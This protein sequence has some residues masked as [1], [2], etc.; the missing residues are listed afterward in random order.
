MSLQPLLLAL[1]CQAPDSPPAGQPDDTGVD[2]GGV[3]GPVSMAPGDVVDMAVASDGSVWAELA[4]PGNY[5]VVLASMAKGQGQ[6]HGYGDDYAE[7]ATTYPPS[8]RP[9]VPPDSRPPRSAAAVGDE[10]TFSVYDGS[11]YAT[12]TG[13]VLSVSDMVVV[14]EDVTTPNELGSIDQSVIDAVIA[15]LEG[16]VI[17]RERQVFGDESDVDGNGAIDILVSYTVN[18]YGAVAYVTQCDIGDVSGCGSRGNG[19]EIVYLGVPDPDDPYGTP[20]GITET[21]AHEL[22]HL[23]YGWHKYVAQGQ[24]DAAENIYLT[25]GMSAL[26]QDLTGYNNGNQYVWAAALDATDYLGQYAT[27]DAVSVNDFLRGSGYYD[28]QR[29]G[30]LR[31]AAY[32]YLRYL[33]EQAGGMAVESDGALV[34]QGGM[35]WLHDWFD[36]PELGPDTVLA[37]TGREVEE[38]SMDFFTALVVSG[39]VENDDPAYNFQPRVVDPVTG[40]E[41]GVDMYALVHGWLQLEGPELQKFERN[42]GELRDGGVEYLK[43]ELEEPGLV[44][45]PVDPDAKARARLLRVD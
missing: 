32:L 12:V 34:D 31:G 17:A 11:A 38:V 1:A 2:S 15:N 3:E 6:S 33:F 20:A 40:Y 23:I 37:T 29:D 16:H 24:L 7:A 22:N 5:I 45:L 41:F 28:T 9:E 44:S 42:D 14:W 43:L 26:A 25:E 8:D 10:R 35:A 13:R 4:E 21:V 27:I 18:Q 36:S 30:A 39:R 19:G